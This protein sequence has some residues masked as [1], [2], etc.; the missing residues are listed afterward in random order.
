MPS[1]REIENQNNLLND[2]RDIME[3]IADLFEEA[4]VSGEMMVDSLTEAKDL[5]QEITKQE[6]E[7]EKKKK[8]KLT[9]Q[10]K[11]NKIPVRA[12]TRLKDNTL[13]K[14]PPISPNASNIVS[15]ISFA[16]SFVLVFAAFSRLL[17]FC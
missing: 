11:F 14:I 4:A 16:R 10:Q 7:Q 1:S 3:E 5:T 2:Q 6:K 9:L 13:D 15:A 8:K 12:P 17:N